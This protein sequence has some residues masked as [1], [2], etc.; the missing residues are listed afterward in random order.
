MVE[1]IKALPTTIANPTVAHAHSL[2][3]SYT[4]M[5]LILRSYLHFRMIQTKLTPM[6]GSLTVPMEEEA[7]FA[8]DPY[9]PQSEEWIT[10]KPYHT[11]LELVA[12]TS[13]RVL[14]RLSLCHSEKWLAMSTQFTE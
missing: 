9:F 5:N 1:D 12:R 13:A 11:I 3:G 6:L 8:I 4:K 14:V 7:K 10:I 2:L